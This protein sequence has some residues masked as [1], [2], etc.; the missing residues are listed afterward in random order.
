MQSATCNLEI[1]LTKVC[2]NYQ[3]LK[4]K[5]SSN[6]LVGAAVKANAYGLGAIAVASALEKIGC[7]NFFVAPVSEGIVLRSNNIVNS[8]IF[9]LTGI[10]KDNINAAHD[11]SI[12]PTI[13]NLEQLHL[14]RDLALKH[15]KTLPCILHFNTGLNRLG[16][17]QTDLQYLANNKSLLD[18]L[19]VKYIM[20]HLSVSEEPDNTYNH[21]QL[22][23]LKTYS[24]VFAGIPISFANSSGIFLN[25]E[26]HFNLARPGAALY[27]INPTPMSQNPMQNPVKL[28]APIIQVQR[29]SA[30]DKVGYNMTFTATK[31]SLIATIPI[32]Y[33]DGYPRALSNIGK[34]YVGNTPVPI[35]GRVSMDLTTIDVSYLAQSEVFIGQSVELIG[36]HLTPDQIGDMCNTNGYEIITRLNTAKR[37]NV[38]YSC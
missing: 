10:Y 23:K 11:Y 34:V 35:A 25:P 20:S 24:S 1:N 6:T 29:L 12:T 38:I 19:E 17:S 37:F 28:T 30:G 31:P 4:T 26:Y 16:M 22:S 27:G 21:Q 18:V 33:A 9:S 32:G 2:A 5:C 14:W 36:E 15:N 3:F 7:T 8:N 13:N